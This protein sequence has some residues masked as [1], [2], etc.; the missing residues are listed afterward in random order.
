MYT[1]DLTESYFPAQGST[2]PAPLTIGA[3]LRASVAR[4]P[5]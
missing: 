1:V 5:R 3:M 4:A 2:E